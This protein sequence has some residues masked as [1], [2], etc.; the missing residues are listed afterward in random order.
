MSIKMSSKNIF[1]FWTH[2][3]NT[4]VLNAN[5]TYLVP[6]NETSWS[7]AHLKRKLM[8]LVRFL[9]VNFPTSV[10]FSRRV[11]NTQNYWACNLLWSPN[12]VKDSDLNFFWAPKLSA[13]G[14]NFGLDS[15]YGNWNISSL[16]SPIRGILYSM[17]W[18]CNLRVVKANIAFSC[19]SF[20]V[21]HLMFRFGLK[22]IMANLFFMFNHMIVCVCQEHKP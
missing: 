3:L 9:F 13:G 16:N 17:V 11:V 19:R 14:L 8:F 2:I 18:R 1:G 20:M 21:R 4:Y 6:L 5:I 15:Q 12:T 10:Q 7:W 22:L